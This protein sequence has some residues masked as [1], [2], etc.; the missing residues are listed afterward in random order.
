MF[1]RKDREYSEMSPLERY[2]KYQDLTPQEI[3]SLHHEEMR[4][5]VQEQQKKKIKEQKEMELNKKQEKEMQYQ[6][7][8]KIEETFKNFFK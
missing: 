4:K 7:V 8:K 5:F 2:Y 6:V 1:Q 3:L